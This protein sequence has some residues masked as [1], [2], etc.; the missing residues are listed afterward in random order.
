MSMSCLY[1]FA[2]LGLLAVTLLGIGCGDDDAVPDAGK[3]EGDDGGKPNDIDDIIGRKDSGPKPDHDGG[4]GRD[5]G[6]D[7]DGATTDHDSGPDRDGATDGSTTEPDSGP[8]G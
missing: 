7:R 3:Q 8:A 1:R 5:G 4:S 2:W 6:S